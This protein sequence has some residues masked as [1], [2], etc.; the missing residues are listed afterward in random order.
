MI[1]YA[2]E[3]IGRTFRKFIWD[4]V[5]INLDNVE[6]KAHDPLYLTTAKTAFPNDPPAR[7]Y[8]PFTIEWP[9]Q[10]S[11]LHAE[12]GERGEIKIRMTHLPE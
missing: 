10:D 2:N 11:S 6:V 4:G 1:K 9:I 8:E 5:T 12:Y 7:E 3:Y